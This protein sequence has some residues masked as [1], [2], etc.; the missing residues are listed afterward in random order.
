[1]DEMA[2]LLTI[3]FAFKSVSQIISNQKLVNNK[4]EYGS[5]IIWTTR[6]NAMPRIF[7]RD[8]R[9]ESRRDSRRDSR[10][11]KEEEEE[12]KDQTEEN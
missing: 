9:R 4:M 1:M 12:E 7:N 8:S 2:R 5:N 3:Q 10:V 6:A 11:N